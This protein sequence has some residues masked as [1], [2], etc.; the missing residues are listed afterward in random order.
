MREHGAEAGN[1]NGFCGSGIASGLEGCRALKGAEL[2]RAC[3]SGE[4]YVPH[5]ESAEFWR[6]VFGPDLLSGEPSPGQTNHRPQRLRE[7]TRGQNRME[8]QRELCSES[9]G[10]DRGTARKK[11]CLLSIEGQDHR[12]W[13][14][15]K[16]SGSVE[17]IPGSRGPYRGIGGSTMGMESG[18]FHPAIASQ[19]DAPHHTLSMS[20]RC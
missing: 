12:L 3:G 4:A 1:P 16:R 2:G 17:Q 14:S 19:P 18:G 6:K 7:Q 8:G 13:A 10:L 9:G 15:T 11:H 20:W 5:C